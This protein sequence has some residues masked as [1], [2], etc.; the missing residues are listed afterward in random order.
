VHEAFEQPTDDPILAAQ[1]IHGDD[2]K[3]IVFQR[4][5]PIWSLQNPVQSD[6]EQLA[7]EFEL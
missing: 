1:R 5:I 6:V 4:Q 3:G 7:G 2:G